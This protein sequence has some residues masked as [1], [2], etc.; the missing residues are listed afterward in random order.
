VLAQQGSATPTFQNLF[1]NCRAVGNANGGWALTNAFNTTLINC[2]SINNV[3]GPQ[4]L[5]S[6]RNNSFLFAD[7]ESQ[8]KKTA[9]VS[10][11][12]ATNVVI[13]G[14]QTF[15]MPGQDFSASGV[16]SNM[17]LIVQGSGLNDRAW[18]IT[19]VATDT[20]SA[21]SQWGSSFAETPSSNV[22]FSFSGANVG[23]WDRFSTGTR[24]VGGYWATL[25][26]GL[27]FERAMNP[28]VDEPYFPNSNLV[29]WNG[30]EEIQL[31]GSVTNGQFK[32][33]GTQEAGWNARI[34]SRSSEP[35]KNNSIWYGSNPIEFTMGLY[36]NSSPNIIIQ[37]GIEGQSILTLLQNYFD[38]K[39]GFAVSQTSEGGKL[40]VTDATANRPIANFQ[41]SLSF[42]RFLVG[43]DSFTTARPYTNV[44]IMPG[45]W[46]SGSTNFVGATNAPGQHLKI[47][48]GSGTGQGLRGLVTFSTF[49][50]LTD[51][52]KVTNSQTL[53]HDIAAFSPYGLLLTDASDT[54]DTNTFYLGTDDIKTNL[55][56]DVRATNQMSMPF[57]MLSMT[58]RSNI[59]GTNMG[60]IWNTTSNRLNYRI[61]TNWH[62]IP[63]F[64]QISGGIDFPSVNT[65]SFANATIAVPTDVTTLDTVLIKPQLN[66]TLMV[67]AACQTNNSGFVVVRAYNP[68]TAAIDPGASTY[69]GWIIKY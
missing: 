46:A 66:Q 9:P 68:G 54:L 31:T 5:N 64:I 33:R 7:V 40:V 58:Q 10:S 63:R 20:I 35:E 38:Q 12:S 36:S 27:V 13:S 53:L 57:P 22:V 51:L 29:G 11:V 15:Q 44:G 19:S 8:D 49:E 2:E 61:E 23:M 47:A 60:F 25:P 41:G 62:P 17:F 6:G 16:Q 69:Q 42:P 59:T 56:L 48:G 37:G 14:F 39:I 18:R 24:V 30:S 34:R 4:I 65:N 45:R 32:L 1:L 26:V 21:S 43:A 52:N 28:I 55:I 67:Q 50:P 3:N